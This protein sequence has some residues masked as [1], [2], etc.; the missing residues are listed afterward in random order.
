MADE[1]GGNDGRHI[2]SLS[3]TEA[4]QMIALRAICIVITI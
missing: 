4:Y 1:G 3:V 2:R